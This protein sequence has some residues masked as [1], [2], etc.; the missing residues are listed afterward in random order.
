[1]KLHG[2][3][4]SP[5]AVINMIH[6]QS[7][8]VEYDL[9]F[10]SGGLGSEEFG[11]VNYMQRIPV[12]ELGDGT[13]IYESAVI[14]EFI[15]DGQPGRSLLGSSDL[16]AANIRLL[17]RLAEL[18]L[19]NAFLPVVGELKDGHKNSRLTQHCL[20]VTLRGLGDVEE[21]MKRAGY[22]F[23]ADITLADCVLV[24]ALTVLSHL[25][26]RMRD[27]DYLKDHP[28]LSAYWDDVQKNEFTAG[29]ISKARQAY[30]L[31]A[32]TGEAM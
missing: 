25:M 13:K 31:R 4:L 26:P 1:M 23:N 3:Y 20:K 7:K 17:A 32:T 11:K 6:L 27:D 12:L 2:V 8:G 21:T 16:N 22:R 5:Y 29:F 19:L 24:P 28:H 30:K 18:Y 14:S 15:E 9:I 10:P